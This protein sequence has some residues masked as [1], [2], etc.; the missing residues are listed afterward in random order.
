MCP[1]RLE[2]KRELVLPIVHLHAHYFA[3]ILPENEVTIRV[4]MTKLTPKRV[5]LVYE[6]FKADG[7]L[8][9]KG[10]TEHAFASTKDFRAIDLSVTNSDIYQRLLQEFSRME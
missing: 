4:H 5:G 2:K 3:P 9:H 8:C 6:L 10:E 1:S 7:T